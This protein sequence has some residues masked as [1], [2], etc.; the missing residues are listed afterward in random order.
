M[1]NKHDC[2]PLVPHLLHDVLDVL[3]HLGKESGEGLV[4]E[5]NLYVQGYGASYLEELA[6]TVGQVLSQGIPLVP[7]PH[8]FQ[9]GLGPFTVAGPGPF[10]QG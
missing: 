10:K 7:H 4:Q 3:Q 9:D 1:G 6:L 5:I 2:A 8:I